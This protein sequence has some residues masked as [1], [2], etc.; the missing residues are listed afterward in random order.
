MNMKKA[1]TALVLMAVAA[2][3]MHAQTTDDI[4]CN[5]NNSQ[6]AKYMTDTQ[7]LYKNVYDNNSIVSAYSTKSDTMFY[8]RALPAVIP[9]PENRPVGLRLRLAERRD[10]LNVRTTEI[11]DDAKEVKIPGLIPQNTYIYSIVDG[12]DNVVKN[13]Y[14][15]TQGSVRMFCFPTVANMRDLGGWHTASGKRIKYGLLFRGSELTHGSRI[16]ISDEDII[17]LRELGIGAEVDMRTFNGNVPEHSVIGDDIRYM[18]IE[19]PDEG[20]M[21]VTRKTELAAV[22]RFV[23]QNLRDGVPTY[24][25]CIY[26]ADRTGMVSV[27]L[28]GLLGVSIKDIYRDYE[29]SSFSPM[30]ETRRNKLLLNRRLYF[31]EDAYPPSK[32]INTLTEDYALNELGLT[33]D[34]LYELRE[35]ALE[36]IEYD[37]PSFVAT[38]V[39]TPQLN[40]CYS[41]QGMPT[42]AASRGLHLVRQQDGTVRKVLV[43]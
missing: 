35:L 3:Q 8:D 37:Y 22:L 27:L 26:G 29:L 20:N 41:I 34:E 16:V 43:K 39:R 6:I 1:I 24:I 7:R 21:V 15:V 9:L 12:D 2:M 30:V 25:H 4:L 13:G 42:A 18:P 17:G 23:L 14:L 31:F 5:L 10:S 33:I 28:E 11:D 36:D 19:M 38:P 40:N 32:D